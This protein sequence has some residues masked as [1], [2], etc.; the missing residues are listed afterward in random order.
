LSFHSS[1]RFTLVLLLAF[2]VGLLPTNP[3]AAAP[4]A[5][6]P[7]AQPPQPYTPP[8][9]QPL[10][11][12]P[13]L[14]QAPDPQVPEIIVSADFGADP[15]IVGETSTITLTVFNGDPYDADDVVLTLPAPPEALALPGASAPLNGA[16]TPTITDSISATDGVTTVAAITGTAALGGINPAAQREWRWDLGRV[17]AQSTTTLTA[18]FRLVR[19]PD[20]EALFVEPRLSARHLAQPQIERVGAIVHGRKP[21]AGRS[22]FAPGRETVLQSRDGRVS[23]RFPANA[24]DK[25]LTLQHLTRRGRERR[26]FAQQD[27]LTRRSADEFELTATDALS[28]TIHRFN[29]PITIGVRYTP[30]QLEALRTTENILTLRWFDEQAQRWVDLTT[31]VIPCIRIA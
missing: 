12:V 15:L 30:E 7:Q 17:D 21:E 1:R 23:V 20:G 4:A 25:P 28:Q 9:P 27:R 8:P 16:M 10:P 14:V 3:I 18:T 6:A 19:M 11:K 26:Q 13:P 24:F 31:T 29:A 5:P 2:V 22:A